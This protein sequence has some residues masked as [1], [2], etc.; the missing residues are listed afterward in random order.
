DNQPE[1]VQ[2]LAK[3]LQLEPA[4]DHV[5]ALFPKKVEQDLLQKALA[6]RGLKEEDIGETHFK[7]VRSYAVE[8]ISQRAKDRGAG[9]NQPQRE[10]SA[11]Q[12]LAAEIKALRQQLDHLEKR[13]AEMEKQK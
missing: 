7:V 9:Q 10:P 2:K 11:V 4:P 6:Y 1:S 8:V 3:A 5:I 12:E 13:L